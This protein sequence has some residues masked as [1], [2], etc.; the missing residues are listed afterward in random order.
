MDR[1]IASLSCFQRLHSEGLR[2]LARRGGA[3]RPGDGQGAAPRSTAH[4]PV[5]PA[6]LRCSPTFPTCS[7]AATTA[8]A[9]P[10]EVRPAQPRQ[11]ALERMLRDCCQREDGRRVTVAHEPELL[12]HGERVEIKKMRS[13]I[14]ITLPNTDSSQVMT[15]DG[16]FWAL[17]WQSLRVV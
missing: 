13:D 12:H 3:R 11:R 7:V 5:L 15:Q 4:A 8:S 10:S 16:R 2:R 9:G 1:I 14:S 17:L 6:A